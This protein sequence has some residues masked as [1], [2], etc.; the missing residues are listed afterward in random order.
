MTRYLF[1]LLTLTLLFAA[2]PP[3]PRLKKP[4]PKL[5]LE[6]R[7]GEVYCGNHLEDRKAP[8]CQCQRRLAAMQRAH[9]DVCQRIA[10]PEA[11]LKCMAE[12]P[13]CSDAPAMDHRDDAPANDSMGPLCRRYC[14]KSNCACCK[15]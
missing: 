9:A 8:P 14:S 10:D 6:A 11:S 4:P 13:G 15:S 1:L 12:S 7:P 2:D 5:T 3:K